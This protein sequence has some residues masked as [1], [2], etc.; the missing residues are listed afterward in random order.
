[1]T[2]DI[3]PIEEDKWVIFN[4]FSEECGISCPFYS[5]C[6]MTLYAPHAVC[7]D[8]SLEEKK[9]FFHLFLY[10]PEGLK[11][12]ILST[13][14]RFSSTISF[15]EPRD[16]ER[17]LDLLLKVNKTLFD[18]KNI[19]KNQG[20]F[21]IVVGD[22]NKPAPKEPIMVFNQ[23]HDPESDPNSLIFSEI[24]TTLIKKEKKIRKKHGS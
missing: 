8:L 6:P 22:Y 11:N 23:A 13:L 21:N 15:H 9:R 7:R 10:G 17:Y 1:M 3:S 5:I 2:T 14:Y 18:G 12:E 16:L 19:T 24:A 20:V 4:N